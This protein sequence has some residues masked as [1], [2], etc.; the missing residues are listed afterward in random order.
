MNIEEQVFPLFESLIQDL[1]K[2]YPE[3]K[4]S[5]YRNYEEC[6]VAGPG[7]GR[8]LS[9]LPKLQAFLDLVH[10]NGKK[11]SRKDESFFETENILE[12][13]SFHNL[14]SKNIS[15]KTRSTIWKYFQTFSILTI[16]LKSG[17]DLKDALKSLNESETSE[18]VAIT[19]KQVASDL[20][21]L[22][23]LASGVQEEIPDASGGAGEADLE[24]M[25]GGMMDSNIGQIAKEVA[26]TMDMDAMFGNVSDST[27][28]M[29]IMSQMMNPEKMS[30]IFQNINQVMNQKM[31]SGEFNQD[32]LKKEAE[33]MY[34][35]MAQN[36]MFSGLMGQ[37]QGSG[38]GS[39]PGSR[40]GSGPG[41][42]S[43]A[44][45]GSGSRPGSRPG[46]GSD[47]QVPEVD[48][49][50]DE[51]RRILKEKIK[52]KENERTGL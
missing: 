10:E 24:G 41:S 34:G 19:D 46:S 20:R 6:L 29:D 31:E 26:E 42:G 32:D 28:P 51:K 52:A 25:L 13:I 30:G 12:E 33:G 5:L 49:T 43:G 2:T 50:K 23:R 27:N 21:T 37:M 38:S 8:V 35:S 45:S 39:R 14:W 11:I 22:K 7:P 17:Q 40:P 9:E 18:E 1:S 47:N 15:D 48:L 36:P 16:N 3:I 44:G 4:N